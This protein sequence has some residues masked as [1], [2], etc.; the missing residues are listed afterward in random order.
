MTD[1]KKTQKNNGS[2]KKG[3]VGKM[4]TDSSATNKIKTSEQHQDSD[5]GIVGKMNNDTGK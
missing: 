3:V 4:N 1:K 2:E 5:K